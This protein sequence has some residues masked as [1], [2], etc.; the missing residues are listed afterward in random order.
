MIDLYSA[1]RLNRFVIL[2]GQPS[3]GKTTIWRTI[4]KAINSLQ[5]KEITNVKVE[6][7]YMSYFYC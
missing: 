2:V 7:F 5:N 3:E 4:T 1:L 6:F